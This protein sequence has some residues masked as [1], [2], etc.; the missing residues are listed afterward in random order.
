MKRM[1]STYFNLVKK[2]IEIKLHLAKIIFPIFFLQ[3]YID[4]TQ[5]KFYMQNSKE[6][7]NVVAWMNAKAIVGF[8]RKSVEQMHGK[9]FFFQVCRTDFLMIG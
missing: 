9:Q 4:E 8:M 5:Q 3:C 6:I 7:N 2:A 1:T